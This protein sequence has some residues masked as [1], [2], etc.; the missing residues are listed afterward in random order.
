MPGVKLDILGN[1]QSAQG[2]IQGLIGGLDKL[3]GFGGAISR[4]GSALTAALSV[5][6]LVN[7]T[8]RAI[9]AAD[10]IGELAE[11]TGTAIQQISGLGAVSASE[12]VS[13]HTLQTGLKGLSEWMVK[14]GQGGRDVNEVLM[15]QADLL[16]SMGN[17]AQR[18]SLAVDRFGRAGQQ[19]IPFL[20]QGS[21]AIRRQVQEAEE[22]GA[23]VGPE[24]AAH[25]GLFD[26]NLQRVGLVFQGMF[27]QIAREL[28]PALNQMLEWFVEFAKRSDNF[29][30]V[31][32][33][34]ATVFKALAIS[35]V[36]V[37]GAFSTLGTFIGQFSGSLA[38]TGNPMEAWR[39]A[40]AAAKVEMDA[41]NKAMEAFNKKVE[42]TGEAAAGAGGPPLAGT[43]LDTQRAFL[44]QA[45]L[46]AATVGAD[47]TI[48]QAQ[49]NRELRD[50]YAQQLKHLDQIEAEL[51][52]RSETDLIA[53]EQGVL[54]TQQ[55]LEVEGELTAAQKQRVEI[56][57][58][59]REIEGDESFVVRMRDN[60]TA[61]ADEW[62][63]LARNA[64]DALTNSIQAGV[65]GVTEAI[66]GAIDGTKTW[67]QVFLQV[68]RS[69]IASLIQVVVQWIAQMTIVRALKR[70]M[71]TEQRTAAAVNAAAEAPA[72]ALA[73]TAS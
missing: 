37:A 23:V 42:E 10:A 66:M 26:R 7:F 60:L 61:L 6:A 50:I 53:T 1:A 32:S 68:G 45:Q 13:L 62:G 34:I 4:L 64:A 56:A 71:D 8:R 2:A 18:V 46:R 21:E 69:I 9:D 44:A 67:G 59:L 29:K 57:Q 31:I 19:M 33:A 41:M 72:A 11:K 73:S 47:T 40:T 16:A 15:E 49:K 65:N 55:R 54:M 51:A 25:A 30:P 14:T 12:G 36:A 20:A 63:N 22:L 43:M 17:T 28:L 5:G 70:I 24:F 58:K 35:A 39:V 52:K 48:S 38:T 3:T 27:N